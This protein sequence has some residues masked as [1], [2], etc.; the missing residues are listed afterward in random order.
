MGT[1]TEKMEALAHDVCAS[2]KVRTSAVKAMLSNA[3]SFMKDVVEEHK[4]MVE[5]VGSLLQGFNEAQQGVAEDLRSA[6][7]AW[8]MMFS[9][10][11]A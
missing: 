10:F 1:F 4:T 2:K 5:K 9:K 3:R 6:S 7:K 11:T 8:S